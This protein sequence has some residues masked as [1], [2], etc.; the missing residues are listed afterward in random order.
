MSTKSHACNRKEI[1]EFSQSLQAL[2][3]RG[4]TFAIDENGRLIEASH[5]KVLS[6]I[7][8]FLRRTTNRLLIRVNFVDIS[9]GVMGY[10]EKE[11]KRISAKEEI[12]S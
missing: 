11:F 1:L 6:E 8:G 9:N 7:D 4:D 5:E 3:E 10:T 12:K 2:A